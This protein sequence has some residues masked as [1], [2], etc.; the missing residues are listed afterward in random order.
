MID[1][2][3]VTQTTEQAAAVIHLTIPREEMPKVFGAAVGELMDVIAAQGISPAGPVFAHHLKMEPAIFDF[4]LGV[5]V[6]EP[7]SAA[8]RVKP[9]RLPA[10]TVARTVYHGPYEGLPG[11]WGEFDAWIQSEGHTRAEDL[12]ECYVDG[13]HSHPDPAG[14]R[15]ELNRPLVD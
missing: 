14:W 6:T 7:V 8:G 15:T 1:R 5:P 13:P 4:E 10:T 11:A 3:R 2:P 12:W 9:G